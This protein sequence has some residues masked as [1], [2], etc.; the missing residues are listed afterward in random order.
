[1]EITFD[2]KDFIKKTKLSLLSPRKLS[3][4]VFL[5]ENW[6]DAFSYYVVITLIATV[7]SVIRTYTILPQIAEDFPDQFQWA[8]NTSI[9]TIL[10]FTFVFFVFS[11]GYIFFWSYLFKFWLRLTLKKKTTLAHS[12]QYYAYSRSP[13]AL[14]GWVPVIGV[15]MSFYTWFIISVG[16]VERE[17]VTMLK[18]IAVV[19]VFHIL[20]F[21]LTGIVSAVLVAV[22]L[23]L[24][25]NG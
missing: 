7:F 13:I 19:T 9:L 17:K 6:K 3:R 4:E 2:I 16:L 25:S 12:I 18:A 22:P 24:M 23:A 14:F 15:F 11:L 8:S 10:P 20:L 5:G 21:I 1:M